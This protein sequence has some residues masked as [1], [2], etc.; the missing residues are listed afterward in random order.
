MTVASIPERYFNSSWIVVG[1]LYTQFCLS[2]LLPQDVG[3]LERDLV[4]WFI[5]YSRCSSLN[6]SKQDINRALSAGIGT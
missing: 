4:V 2:A 1:W 6:G 3:A 5:I